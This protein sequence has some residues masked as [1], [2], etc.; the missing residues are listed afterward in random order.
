MTKRYLDDLQS[1]GHPV[2][3][4]EWLSTSSPSL[5]DTLRRKGWSKAVVKPEISGGAHRTYVV[6]ADT[7]PQLQA[8]IDDLLTAADVMVQPFL[9]EIVDEGE[10]SLVFFREE[11]SHAIVKRP[12]LGDFRVQPQHGGT[13]TPASPPQEMIRQ[14]RSI[15]EEA[16]APVLYAR[17]DG[18][19][20]ASRLRL[21]EL[22]VIEPLLYFHYAPGSQARFA[23][24]LASM[25]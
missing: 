20:T 16:P 7:A 6:T 5:P 10:W 2:V 4:T 3:E 23:R 1:R 25:L 11:F 12:A 18:I 24:A 17:V 14:A 22:E 8:E 13:V 15:I 9:H 19:R 21:I